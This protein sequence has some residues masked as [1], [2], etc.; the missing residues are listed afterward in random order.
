MK[1]LVK[2]TNGN[3]GEVQ[4][5]NDREG[6]NLLRMGQVSGGQDFR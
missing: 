2:M 3:G 5:G 1:L 6:V 4:G